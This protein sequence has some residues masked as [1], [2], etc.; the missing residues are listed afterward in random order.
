MQVHSFLKDRC[1]ERGHCVQWGGK[2]NVN[3]HATKRSP[4]CVSA[5]DRKQLPFS[6]KRPSHDA[7]GRGTVWY[8]YTQPRTTPSSMPSATSQWAVRKSVL[9]DWSIGLSSCTSPM[10]HNTFSNACF[11]ELCTRLLLR[12]PKTSP[13]ISSAFPMQRPSLIILLG[14]SI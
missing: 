14:M 12:L 7:R 13:L 11:H 9:G 8:T 1:R 5:P 2:R 3:K 4:P 6:M 10:N